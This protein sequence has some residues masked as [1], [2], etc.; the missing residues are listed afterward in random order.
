MRH[1]EFASDVVLHCE[2][3]VG[4]ETVWSDTLITRRAWDVADEVTR[5]AFRD[6]AREALA[7]A[8]IRQFNP[9]VTVEIPA[10]APSDPGSGE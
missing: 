4:G 5:E 7:Q 8:I 6:R 9:A 1:R 2:L 10:P 3:E